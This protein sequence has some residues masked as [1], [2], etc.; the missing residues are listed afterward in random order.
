M[1]PACGPIALTVFAVTTGGLDPT[2]SNLL[3]KTVRGPR[4]YAT[5]TSTVIQNA[6]I[7]PRLRLVP[8]C[9]HP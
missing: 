1:T 8:I 3:L 2:L 5:P 9:D 4:T 7:N 6:V